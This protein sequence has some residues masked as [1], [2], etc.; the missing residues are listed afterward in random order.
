[1]SGLGEWPPAESSARYRNRWD[2]KDETL[3]RHKFMSLFS[4]KIPS[5]LLTKTSLDMVMVIVMVMVLVR[6]RVSGMMVL[7]SNAVIESGRMRL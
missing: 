2:F 4:P 7:V 1:M 6:F 5:L 3:R